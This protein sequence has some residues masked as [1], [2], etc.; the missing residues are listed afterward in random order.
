MNFLSKKR[1]AIIFLAALILQGFHMVEHFTQVYQFLVLRMPAFEAHGLLFFLDLEWNHFSFN[2][3]YFL[4]LAYVYTGYKFY[5]RKEFA[6]R[7]PIPRY[8]FLAGFFIQGYHVIEHSAR[9]GQFLQSGCTPCEGIL[10]W[11]FNGILLHFTLNS[12]TWALP[13]IAFFA[14]GL[15]KDLRRPPYHSINNKY[16]IIKEGEQ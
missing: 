12:I 3:L 15:Y 7:N 6:G 10:G 13:M 1:V 16:V 2:L 9:I 8:A 14:Y 5:D 4:L 11:F